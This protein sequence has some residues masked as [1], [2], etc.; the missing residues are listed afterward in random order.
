MDHRSL[1]VNFEVA[2][3]SYSAPDAAEMAKWM[4]EVMAHSRPMPAPRA[5]PSF[6][7]RLGEQG[8]ALTLQ[9]A[10]ASMKRCTSPRSA[11]RRCF[12]SGR[13]FSASSDG[14]VGSKP[15]AGRIASGNFAGCAV[16]STT[17]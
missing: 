17:L 8:V 7:S 1:F 6:G 13:A 4:R 3:V 9:T 5:K 2:V 15:T 11:R 10:C 16:E 14:C 12:T